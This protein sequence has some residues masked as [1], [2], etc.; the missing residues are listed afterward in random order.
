[1]RKINGIGNDYFESMLKPTKNNINY[2]FVG[3]SRTANSRVGG[4]PMPGVPYPILLS[5]L[6]Y[7]KNRGIFHNKAIWGVDATQMAND[8]AA[9]VYPLRPDDTTV[10]KSYLFVMIGINDITFGNS[11]PGIPELIA[12]VKAYCTQATNDGFKVILMTVFPSSYESEQATADRLE[13]NDGLRSSDSTVASMVLDIEELIGDSID[14][15]FFEDGL[16]LRTY[17]N[18]YIANYINHIFNIGLG[19][20]IFIR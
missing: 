14:P 10:K 3:D 17:G 16:H 2:V 15:I 4:L 7:F 8:Y 12:G 11:Y 18:S 13:Y 19:E 20:N 1:M 9:N 6:S 5:E